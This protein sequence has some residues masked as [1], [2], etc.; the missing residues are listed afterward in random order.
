VLIALAVGATL[1]A[2]PAAAE[3]AGP[4]EIAASWVT[5]VTSTSANLRASIKANELSTTYRFE[6]ITEAA[7]QANLNAIP[8]REGFF[9]A[10]KAPISG[11]ALVGSAPTPLDVVQHPNGLTPSTAYRYRPVAS[12]S[13]NPSVVGPEHVL[14]TQAPTNVFTLPDGRG[15]ELVSPADKA[16][17]AIAVPGALFGGGDFQA[18]AA[19]GAVTYGSATAFGTA[20][21]APPASQYVSRRSA[22]GWSTENVSA[23]LESAAYGDDPDGAPYRLFSEDLARSLLFGGLACRGDLPGC[24]APNPV[25]PGTG[26]PAG[27]MAYYL[28]SGGAFASLLSAAEVVHSAVSPEAFEASFAAASSDLAH[29]VLSSCAKLTADAT[30]IPAGPGECVAAEQNLYEWSGG[31][32]S[33]V[34]LLPGET[35][36]TP[37]AQIAAPIGA[38]SGDGSRVYFTELEDG[39]LYLHEEGESTKLIPKTVGGGA[40]FQVASAD[41]RFAYFIKGGS[42]YRYDA[43]AEAS[44]PLAAGVQGVL[45]ASADGTYVYFQDATALKLW[46]SG[47]TTTVAAGADAAKESDYHTPSTGTARVS[48]DGLHLAF[49]SDAEIPPFDNLDANT[50][51]PDTELYLY[52]PPPGGGAA[53]LI[54]ASC[55][56]TGERPKGSASIPGALVNGSTTAYKPRVLSANGQRL[57]FDSAD[58]LVIPDSDSR[59]DVYQWEAKGTGDCARAPGCV[60]LVSGGRTSGGSFVDASADGSDAYFLSGETLVSTDP[61]SIDIYDARVGGGF[62]IP[63]T[64]IVCIGDACQ[65]LPSPPDDP[66]PGTLTKNSGNP[67]LRYFKQKKKKTQ[68]QGQGQGQKKP[69]HPKHGHKKQPGKH[70]RRGNR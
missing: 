59:P 68:G 50:K 22:A 57:F 2:A 67:P 58:K 48:A 40:S 28:R 35:T 62:P 43:Q 6:Y 37:G 54:C 27:Y 53:Q 24:P 33:L 23:P 66:T 3:A 8:P 26:A 9:G 51:L 46:H 32:L 60:D 36:G 38:I 16:G 49:L 61:G 1:L 5:D 18:A 21:G 70:G 15:W 41:G 25:L 13:A 4:P 44:E 42:L 52:G 64:P 34:N 65:A 11:S 10:V 19:G 63:E 12:N 20:A 14:T 31:A 69:K 30:E 56:P 55:N 17:G 45:G 29:V 47:T 39:A 7:Y